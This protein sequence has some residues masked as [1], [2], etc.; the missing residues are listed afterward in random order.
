MRTTRRSDR[1]GP[2]AVAACLAAILVAC[3][4][5]APQLPDEPLPAAF[6]QGVPEPTGEVVLTVATDE[7]SRDWD[8]ATLADLPQHE[9]TV[10]EP[11]V[12]EEHTYTG[13]F[14]ADV[15]RASGVDLEAAEAVEVVALD[16]F[17]ADLP[18]DAET[19]DG[20]LLAHLQDGEEI[21][22]AEGGPLRLVFPPGNPTGANLNNWIWSVR[23]ATV[24]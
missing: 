22:V 7:G 24:R 8:V 3:S 5:E 17:V 13:P 2:V 9:L 16:D 10:L 11:F 20:L 19:L 6:E 12:E 15:L 18:V 23:T 1:L 14:W 21:P 4:E